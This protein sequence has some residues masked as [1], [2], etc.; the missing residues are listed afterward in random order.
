MVTAFFERFVRI[1]T[2]N[3][4]RPHSYPRRKPRDSG[5]KDWDNPFTREILHE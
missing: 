2:Y 1:N 3:K 4:E 5:G